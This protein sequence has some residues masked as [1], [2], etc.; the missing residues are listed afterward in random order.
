MAVRFAEDLRK[1]C[2]NAVDTM[3][4][5]DA[6]SGMTLASAF[7]MQSGGDDTPNSPQNRRTSK[8]DGGLIRRSPTHST[9]GSTVSKDDRL[10]RLDRSVTDG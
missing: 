2:E 4:G 7:T 6:Q 3:R 10:D 8:S 5:F 1:A 9:R